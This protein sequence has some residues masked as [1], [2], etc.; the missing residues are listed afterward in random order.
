MGN[1]IKKVKIKFG[2]RLIQVTL[3]C[4]A[5]GILTTE[6]PRD[7]QPVTS[8]QSPPLTYL[9]TTNTVYPKLSQHAVFANQALDNSL[10]DVGSSGR[11]FTERQT[12][13]GYSYL[14]PLL[15]DL[16][17]PSKDRPI[18]S[19]TDKQRYGTCF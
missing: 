6:G 13:A 19:F 15:I 16:K 12:Q 17:L 7:F 8:L 3:V 4:L 10:K 5:S 11:H 2:N 1:T 9:P 14:K 18:K